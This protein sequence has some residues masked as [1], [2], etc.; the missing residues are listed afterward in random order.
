ML[1]TETDVFRNKKRLPR[2]RQPKEKGEM[3]LAYSTTT[4]FCSITLAYRA[5]SLVAMMA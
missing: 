5:F 4:P 3:E 2:K 1:R